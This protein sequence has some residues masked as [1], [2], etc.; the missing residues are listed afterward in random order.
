MEGKGNRSEEN[1]GGVFTIWFNAIQR[2]V[3]F[4]EIVD[5]SAQEIAQKIQDYDGF[6]VLFDVSNR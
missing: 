2:K 1:G 5:I 6:V 4:D 3:R